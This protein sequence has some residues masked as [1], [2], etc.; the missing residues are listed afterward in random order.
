MYKVNKLTAPQIAKLSKNKDVNDAY[1]DLLKVINGEA[2]CAE[3]SEAI[4]ELDEL[5]YAF[6]TTTQTV[7]STDS[8]PTKIL[9]S[10]SNAMSFEEFKNRYTKQVLQTPARG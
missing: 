2:E 4:A 5:I 6:A 8:E 3:G 10:E 7:T 9:K 1:T